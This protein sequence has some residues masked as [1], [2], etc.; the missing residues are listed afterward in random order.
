MVLQWFW[1]PPQPQVYNTSPLLSGWLDGLHT[2]S[3]GLYISLAIVFVISLA[4]G[5]FYNYL[6]N[7]HEVLFKQTYLPVLFFFYFSH[8]FQEQS[9]LTP[10]FF[11]SLFILLIVYRYLSLDG[12]QPRTTPFLDMGFFTGMAFCLTPDTILFVPA[13]LLALI[14]SAYLTFKTFMLYVTG[15]IIP[16]YFLGIGYFLAGQWEVYTIFFSTNVFAFDLQRLM[17]NPYH[18]A[19]L[20]IAAL[21]LLFSIAGLRDNY[22]KN[23]IRA[24]KSQQMLFYM[25]LSALSAVVL[26]KAPVGQVFTFVALPLSPFVSYYFI[27]TKMG[28]FR[29]SLFA[30]LFVIIIIAVYVTRFI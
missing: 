13:I 9:I 17:I 27:K 3:T 16:L 18:A 20:G 23:T 26:S 30:L 15:F 19:I 4:V 24:R 6:V 1:S 10:H 22:M 7:E 5:F 29:E 25:L 28:W 21:V 2:S 11:A 8:L 14:A 12:R